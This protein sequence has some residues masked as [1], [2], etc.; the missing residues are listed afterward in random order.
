MVTR[1]LATA[2]L[3]VASLAVAGVAPGIAPA[4]FA[5]GNSTRD[6]SP[7]HGISCAKGVEDMEKEVKVAAVRGR[8]QQEALQGIEAA[9]LACQAGDARAAER[10]LLGVRQ[11]LASG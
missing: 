9:R 10:T 1:L 8:Q 4:A 6:L 7:S 11:L 3:A 2:A 5:S